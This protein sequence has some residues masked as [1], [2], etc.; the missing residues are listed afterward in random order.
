VPEAPDLFGAGPLAAGRAPVAFIVREPGDERLN[1]PWRPGEDL[2][3]A[4]LTQQH[5]QFTLV[6]QRPVS[7]VRIDDAVSHVILQGKTRA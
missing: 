1:M 6:V 3:Q 5:E 2:A 4:A 7:R